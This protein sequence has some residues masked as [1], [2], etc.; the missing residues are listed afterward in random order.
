MAARIPEIVNAFP[1]Q[2]AVNLRNKNKE[3]K[4]GNTISIDAATEQ[5][6]HPRPT[7]EPNEPSE[8]QGTEQLKCKN[9]KKFNPFTDSK[10]PPLGKNCLIHF[11]IRLI[12]MVGCYTHMLVLHP[13]LYMI[14]NLNE[15]MRDGKTRFSF[16]SFQFTQRTTL[17]CDRG[18]SRLF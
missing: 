4:W 8:M 14:V 10:Y 3:E 1:S 17:V 5:N 2:L 13:P 11:C 16:P 12:P 7:I 9:K 18:G 6:M 15:N